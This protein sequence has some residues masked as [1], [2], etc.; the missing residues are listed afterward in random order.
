MSDSCAF[1]WTGDRYMSVGLV[2]VVVETEAFGRQLACAES[3]SKPGR[4]VKRTDVATCLR[5]LG[6][7][8]PWQSH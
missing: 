1:M 8:S 4:Y 3:P 7:R 6:T 2:H 5:C